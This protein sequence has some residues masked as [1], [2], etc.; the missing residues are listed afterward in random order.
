[1]AAAAITA[2][3][4]T[5]SP[6]GVIA[7]ALTPSTATAAIAPDVSVDGSFGTSVSSL[8][9]SGVTLG[10]SANYLLAFVGG[11]Q[12]TDKITGVTFNSV[13]MTLLGKFYP[14]SALGWTYLFGLANPTTGGSQSI[15]VSASGSC[16][17]ISLEAQSYTNCS[18]TQPNT[19]VTASFSN[20]PT[21]WAVIV[22]VTAGCWG[23]SCSR[24][25]GAL[26]TSAS[27]SGCG[28]TA[29]TRVTNGGSG[30]AIIDTNGTIPFLTPVTLTP[31]NAQ[32]RVQ[33]MDV[34]RTK[35]EAL[36]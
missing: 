22:P 31:N 10:A 33:R 1:M 17:V 28:T 7:I 16:S 3:S 12:S 35:N 9:K 2:F 21:A 36:A 13:S 30:L 27:C 34:S 11:D 5:P 26:L 20:T 4:V 19:L 14:G 24:L 23:V 8:T 32:W 29:V 25:S 6:W 15:V 18:P